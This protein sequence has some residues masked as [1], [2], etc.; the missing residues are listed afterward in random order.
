MLADPLMYETEIDL[1]VLD[2]HDYSP[3][4]LPIVP[5]LAGEFYVNR[6]QYNFEKRGKASKATLIKYIEP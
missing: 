3:F 5:E 1:D 2:L 6:L 4:N